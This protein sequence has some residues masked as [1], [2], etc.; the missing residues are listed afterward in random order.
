LIATCR[1]LE[2]ESNWLLLLHELG[3]A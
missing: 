1:R 2:Q 3:K